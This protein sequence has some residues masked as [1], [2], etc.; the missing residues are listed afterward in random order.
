MPETGIDADVQVAPPREPPIF[1]AWLPWALGTFLALLCVALV[2]YASVARRERAEL[3][4]KLDEAKQAQTDL[5][6]EGDGLQARLAAIVSAASNDSARIAALEKQLA[7]RIAEAQKQKTDD[8]KKAEEAQALIISARRALNVSQSQLAQTA[9]DLNRARG[10]PD[11][12]TLNQGNALDNLRIGMLKPT[13][14]GPAS[15]SGIGVWEI[16]EQKGLLILENLAPLPPDRDYQLWL[17]D[18]KFATPVSG[19]VIA[20]D[21]TGAARL[22]FR[23]ATLIETAD[24]FA[25]S[26]ERKGGVSGSP[27]G[28]FLM[29]S[30]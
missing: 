20:V 3:A 22:E 14:D 21:Q 10:L 29:I 17:Y 4:R 7:Q 5:Q 25:I 13:T 24:R 28:R 9:Q 27:Q 2:G 12:N 26:L 15:A 11:G 30:N 1:P 23:A 19:G 16:H 6:R 8:D 18:P